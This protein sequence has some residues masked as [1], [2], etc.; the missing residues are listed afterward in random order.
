MIIEGQRVVLRDEPRETDADDLFAWLQLEEWQYYD[1]P[2]VPFAPPN[3]A[4]FEA[5]RSAGQIPPDTRKRWEVDTVEGQHIGWVCWY[6][7]NRDTGCT[8]VGVVLPDPQMW[9]QGYGPE[10][11]HLLVRTL[12]RE[13]GLNTVKAATWSGNRRSVGCILKCGFRE[14]ARLPHRAARSVRGEPLERVEFTATRPKVK[15]QTQ[16]LPAVNGD[17]HDR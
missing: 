7:L 4:A 2:D 16:E 3:R 9:G 6:N 11:L 14:T 17:A 10:A 13:M 8:Y 5:S 12:F 1:E 15:V